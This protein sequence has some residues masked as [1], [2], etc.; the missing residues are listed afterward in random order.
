MLT[1]GFTKNAWLILLAA[2]FVIGAWLRIANPPVA[3]PRSPDERVYMHYV[4]KCAAA[5]LSAPRELVAAYNGLPIFWTYPIPL[6]VSYIYL[7]VLVMKLSGATPEH[8]GTAVSAGASILQLG[9]VALFGARF[10][11]RWTAVAA[12]ALLAV[13]PVDLAMSRRIWC[14]GVAGCAAMILLWI[15]VEIS[16]RDRAKRRWFAALWIWSAFFLLLKES[17]GIYFGFCIGGL[18]V[19]T[20]RR[21]HSWKQIGYILAGAILAAACAF[22]IMTLLCGGIGAAI[23]TAHHSAQAAPTNKYGINFQS[24]PWYSIPLALGLL[25]PLTACGVLAAAF[26]LAANF[27]KPL[28]SPFQRDIAIWLSLLILLTIVGITLPPA[29]KN[30]RYISFV[31][32]PWYLLGA[33]GFNQAV[34]LIIHSLSRRLAMLV[35][36]VAIGALSF[37]SVNDLLR[38]RRLFIHLALPDLNVRQMI[39]PPLQ[40]FSPAGRGKISGG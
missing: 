13:S 25:S 30:L 3:A 4:Q 18:A 33:F 10:F 29:L 19:Q 39:S 37:G 27:K 35:V 8:A 23:E 20:W 14:D 17:G 24:G 7:I 16:S 9:I 6:R 2:I 40:P 36:M 12:V 1:G 38:Y 34:I 5:P 11:N 31:I 32:G 28:L 22:G 21:S 15:C 26:L